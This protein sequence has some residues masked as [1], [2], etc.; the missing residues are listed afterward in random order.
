MSD[1][2]VLQPLQTKSLLLLEELG[3]I[4]GKTRGLGETIVHLDNSGAFLLCCLKKLYLKKAV[5]FVMPSHMLSTFRFSILLSTR[6]LFWES[7][8]HLRRILRE[9]Y[10]K[11]HR[12]IDTHLSVVSSEKDCTI[13]AADCSFLAV[14]VVSSFFSLQGPKGR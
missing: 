13:F 1:G 14:L 11:K 10:H 4:K 3:W 7:G 6:V 12:E 9:R 8:C 2:Q 5:E